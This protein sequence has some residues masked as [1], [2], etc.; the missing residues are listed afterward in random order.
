MYLYINAFIKISK[1]CII[2]KNNYIESGVKIYEN[3][4]IEIIIKYMMEQ[5]FI[6]IQ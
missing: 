3:V 6:Q 4:I 5:L 1:N 2:G